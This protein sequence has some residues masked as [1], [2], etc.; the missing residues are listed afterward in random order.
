MFVFD[1]EITAAPELR[2]EMISGVRMILGPLSAEPACCDCHCYEDIDEKTILLRSH[3]KS[4]TELNAYLAS[5]PFRQTLEW[6]ESS[7]EPPRLRV[8]VV[9]DAN[10]MG[11]IS[12]IRSIH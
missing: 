2:R 6:M 11:L 3:W 7:I 1:I 12:S 9:L 10:A 4:Q 8:S 5:E